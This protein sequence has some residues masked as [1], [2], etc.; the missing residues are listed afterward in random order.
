[1]G[2]MG[3]EWG[4]DWIGLDRVVM[5]DGLD[6]LWEGGTD[7]GLGWI[8]WDG[9]HQFGPKRPIPEMGARLT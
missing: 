9:V 5:Q 1:M 4:L 6:G 3:W 8:G 2:W 7:W